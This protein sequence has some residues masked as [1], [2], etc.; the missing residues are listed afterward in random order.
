MVNLK[1][2]SALSITAN[3]TTAYCIFRQSKLNSMIYHIILKSLQS[4]CQCNKY[5]ILTFEK[6]KSKVVYLSL[7]CCEVAGFQ[8]N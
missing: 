4:R 6:Y 8:I 5:F 1:E 2:F 3:M 7:K